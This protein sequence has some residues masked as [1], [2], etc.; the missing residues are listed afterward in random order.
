M[1]RAKPLRS[2]THRKVTA[3]RTEQWV[4]DSFKD[5]QHP[6]VGEMQRFISQLNAADNEERDTA[7]LHPSEMCKPDWCPR[8]AG[9]GE[10]PA[11]R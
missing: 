4:I 5:R 6:L 1:G 8:A 7:H 2:A 10:A 11:A 9:A 3:Q